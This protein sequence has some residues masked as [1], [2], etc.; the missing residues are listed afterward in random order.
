ME[1]D[2]PFGRGGGKIRSLVTQSDCHGLVCLP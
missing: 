2:G 1:V